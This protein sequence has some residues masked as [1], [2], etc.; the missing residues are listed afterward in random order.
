MPTEVE[1]NGPVVQTDAV[2]VVPPLAIVNAQ[3]PPDVTDEDDLLLIV[4]VVATALAEMAENPPSANA[5]AATSAMRLIDVF[6]DIIFL[7]IVTD[8][9]IPPVALR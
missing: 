6:V 9:T 2:A 4:N 3:A 8:E 5:A 7:S 1:L